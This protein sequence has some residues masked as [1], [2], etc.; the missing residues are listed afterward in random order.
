ML[1][2]LGGNEHKASVNTAENTRLMPCVPLVSLY[3]ERRGE[4][5]AWPIGTARHTHYPRQSKLGQ[6]LM[7]VC[8]LWRLG[9]KW[10]P[11]LLVYILP[12]T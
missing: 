10:F 2:R 8:R 7:V 11:D 5:K 1:R 3:Q 6:R 12:F 4:R 9:R